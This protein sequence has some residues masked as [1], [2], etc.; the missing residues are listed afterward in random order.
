MVDHYN[1][2][3][4]PFHR[5]L[6]EQAGATST[7]DLWEPIPGAECVCGGGGGLVINGMAF[8]GSDAWRVTMVGGGGARN[9]SK[10]KKKSLF[11]SELSDFSLAF[12]HNQAKTK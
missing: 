2:L 10:Y 8:Q 9:K 4:R 1:A 6:Q 3:S 5:T 11:F 7:A 12:L